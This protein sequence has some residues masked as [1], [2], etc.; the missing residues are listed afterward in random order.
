MIKGLEGRRK[1]VKRLVWVPAVLFLTPILA[2]AVDTAWYRAQLPGRFR[3]ANWEGRWQTHDYYGLTGRLAVL[4]PDPLPEGKAF[5]AEAMV[6]YPIYSVWKTG[7]FVRMNFVG[8]FDPDSPTSTGETQNRI[9]A[10]QGGKLSFKGVAGN[11]VV[12]Y[13]AV[14]D[15][16]RTGI[17]GGYV[18]RTPQDHGS[19]LIRY[20]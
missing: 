6:Y 5:R 3:A 1:W 4:L 14:I 9:P 18:S 15:D 2:G 8:R 17:V 19:F 7:Q 11:Q 12:D 16:D 20:R 13:V 10:G